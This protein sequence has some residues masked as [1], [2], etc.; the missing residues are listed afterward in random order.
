[1]PPT[2]FERL[3]DLC[4]TGDV[5]A[6]PEGTVVFGGEPL[7]RVTAPLIEAQL[8]E[9]FL[10]A[11]INSVL[12]EVAAEPLQTLAGLFDVEEDFLCTFPEL[13]H[14]PQ[15][16]G[17]RYWGPIFVSDDGVAPAW[18]SGGSERIFAYLYP[19][20]RDFDKVVEQRIGAEGIFDD[21]PGR[22][23]GSDM[24]S[25]GESRSAGPQMRR[26][27][28]I[29]GTGQG[30]NAHRLGNPAADRKVGLENIDRLQQHL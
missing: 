2:W 19:S 22:R 3:I 10:L 26:E 30:G 5:W 6:V 15:R 29:V 1:M 20:Y 8:A 16:L 12:G 25:G 9:T 23:G 17:A 27:L 4:F 7:L 14:Y 11:T 28:Q 24:Q 13:D 21:E 18:P